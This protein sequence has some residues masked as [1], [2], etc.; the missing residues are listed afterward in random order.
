[1]NVLIIDGYI[2]EPACFGVS[3]YLSPYPRYIAGALIE[4]NFSEQEI[5]YITIDEIRQY[6]KYENLIKFI[7]ILII[8]A[9][10]T[11]PGKYYN[12][13]PITIDEIN[14]IFNISKGI[15]I[16]GGPIKFGYSLH[17]GDTAIQ[18]N[19]IINNENSKIIIAKKDLECLIYD[20]IT[21]N[22][23]NNFYNIIE[24]YEH[25][26]RT[27][28]EIKRWAK[29]GSF[30]VKKH[31]KYPYLICEIETYRGC[32]RKKKCSFCTEVFYG[33]PKF[34]DI[35][36]IIEEVQEL[37]FNG[38]FNFRIGGQADLFAYNGIDENEDVLK[39]NPI[40]IEKLYKGI[41]KVAPLLKMLHM[42]NVNPLTIYI[43][44][45]ESKKIIKSIVK[46]HTPGDVIALGIESLDPNVIKRNNLKV[47]ENEAFDVINLINKIG[48]KR[49]E[50]GMPEILPGLNFI[51]G[52]NG[53]TKNTFKKNYDFLLNIVESNLLLRRINIRRLISFKNIKNNSQNDYPYLKLFQY[54]KNKTRKNIDNPILKKMFPKGSILKSV[55]IENNEY[56]NNITFC[57]QFGTYPLLVGIQKKYEKKNIFIDISITGYGYRSLTGI[58]YPININNEN[59]NLIKEI[60]YSN[61]LIIKNILKLRPFKNIEDLKNRIKIDNEEFFKYIYI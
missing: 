26:F 35:K 55:F 60:P 47:N 14:S 59:I 21:N 16:I 5:Y 28:E 40:I 57:R 43:Y 25:R 1:M 52:L 18:L 10:I 36:S 27:N 56:K 24:K 23:R 31:P 51:Y 7:D 17:G 54:Y 34:R 33:T 13:K 41:R 11:V 49:G 15:K 53:E 22:K 39:P 3:P 48:S 2:D 19:K 50:N 9:G 46:Y 42:D 45:E 32:T 38:I 8:I 12:A 44:P 37:Y 58:P 29:K 30:I 20:T 4:K 61:K 6:K